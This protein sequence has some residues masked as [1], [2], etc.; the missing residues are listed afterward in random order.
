[1]RI[2]AVITGL[3]IVGSAA[4]GASQS[5]V[6]SYDVESL[7]IV[8]VGANLRIRKIMGEI[9]TFMI[10]TFKAG[11][12]NTPHHHTHEQINVG[13]T[14]AFDI[15]TPSTPHRVARL[16]G[17]VIPADVLHGND[18]SAATLD[19]V[20]IEFQPVRRVDFPPEREKVVFTRA[21]APT[22]APAGIDLDFRP[23]SPSWQRHASGARINVKDGT[24]VAV[25]AWEFPAGLK[26][27]VE[28]P[29]RVSGAE[30]FVYV[31]DGSVEAAVGADRHA[32]SAGVLLV[33][34]PDSPAPRVRATAAA[35]L[36]IFEAARVRPW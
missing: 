3:V 31:L 10:G 33:I 21:D 29:P 16:Q 19:P 17:L 1:M 15:V 34:A 28:I 24:G 13:V 9:G 14:G 26:A 20:L 2:T 22:P 36:L 5:R 30:M 8:E 4:A 18:V 11:W 32:A 7:P 23:E 27:A 25:S 35:T 12:K 6:T